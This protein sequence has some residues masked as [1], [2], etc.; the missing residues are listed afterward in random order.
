M[1]TM[2]RWF[3]VHTHPNGEARAAMH[4]KQ[5]GF[6]AY[7]PLYMKKRRHARRVDTV[8]RPLFPR[9]LFVRLDPEFDQW[10]PINSTFGVSQLVANDHGPIPLPEGVIE[11]VRGHEIEGGV[12]VFDHQVPFAPHQRLEIVDGPMTDYVGIF[13]C[14]SNSDRV[15]L[16]LELLNKSIRVTLPREAVSAA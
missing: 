1:E 15:V 13:E 6:E 9:Y 10:R 11:E 3:A 16:L 7:L 12:I 4:L 14:M 5:Q 8:K 2:K